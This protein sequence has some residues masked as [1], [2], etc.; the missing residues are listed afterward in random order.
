MVFLRKLLSTGNQSH[1]RFAVDMWCTWLDHRLPFNELQEE[2]IVSALKISVTACHD[3]QAW[4]FGRLEQMFRCGDILSFI[5][6][7]EKED[8]ADEY[9]DEDS[10]LAR[11]QFSSL[12]MFYQRNASLDGAA[13][14]GLVFQKLLSCLIQ[15]EKAVLWSKVSSERLPIT[16]VSGKESDI[17]KWLLDLVSN[18]KYFFHW[19][20][21]DYDDML[22]SSEQGR[23]CDKNVWWKFVARI[24]IGC[25][26]C[27]IAI[28]MLMWRQPDRNSCDTS[29]DDVITFRTDD[30]GVSVWSLMEV[31]FSFYRMLQK[32]SFQYANE[33][34]TSLSK[35]Y[36]KAASYGLH[37]VLR[38]DKLQL[39]TE[40]KNIFHETTAASFPHNGRPNG[41]S[42][43]TV[44]F[45]LDSCC[46]TIGDEYLFGKICP[47]D[48][49]L[50]DQD[51]A[52]ILEKL[53]CVYINVR[54]RIMRSPNFSGAGNTDSLSHGTD[55]MND[56]TAYILQF[57][58]YA[59]SISSRFPLSARHLVAPVKNAREVVLVDAKRG[60]EILEHICA[61][62]ER[63][64]DRM[65]KIGKNDS[66]N[67]FFRL[68]R[69]FLSDARDCVQLEGLT[70][71][72]ISC[73][74][75]NQKESRIEPTY[76]RV[77][78]HETPAVLTCNSHASEIVPPPF[79]TTH[80]AM[81]QYS[82]FEAEK[83]GSGPRSS[84]RDQQLVETAKCLHSEQRA[85]ELEQ[86]EH[87]LQVDACTTVTKGSFLPVDTSARAI[88]RHPR[89]RP[90]G[91]QV[92]LNVQHLTKA[93]TD[94]IDQMKL[95]L[96][97]GAAATRYSYAVTTGAG[98]DFPT[99][100]SDARNAFGRSSTFT[101]DIS[102]PTKRHGE[103]TEP[104]CNHDERLGASVHQRTALNRLLNLLKT[105]PE[106][107]RRL[108]DILRYGV[109]TPS[110]SEGAQQPQL[111][112]EREH[113]EL[114]D[115]HAAF[116]ATGA[117]FPTNSAVRGVPTILTDKEV[118][119]IFM[120]FDVDNIG[121]IQLEPF[122]DYCTSLG[123]KLPFSSQYPMRPLALW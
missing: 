4:S 83:P 115:F 33:M 55:G 90:L 64:L 74:S 24:Y 117:A 13:S 94:S 14:I 107:S 123:E 26:I 47:Q 39:F 101:N 23:T 95:D 57:S 112:D 3:I 27:N 63:T 59:D 6:G 1:Q 17:K 30:C 88:K 52:N 121:A 31:E 80:Q 98:L 66:S 8:V 111:E 53:L 89:G 15:F 37:R 44:V 120:Y 105:D 42:F 34:E 25:G 119:H 104:G 65:V 102:D 86:E 35:D 20:C 58:L 71:L 72:S 61:A 122:T 91:H 110:K 67:I 10:G 99:T 16:G 19:I 93:E 118:I 70:K 41:M 60:E 76:K 92:D 108:L 18:W 21:Q 75:L 46:S 49:E 81:T 45:V 84:L 22:N 43:D 29:S 68:A 56:D 87:Q 38:R 32:V 7:Y 97:Q 96:L 79:E 9:D 106:T 50:D 100:V 113:I 11:F 48:A 116:S 54:D 5:M 2:E 12:D 82:D 28:E 103:A 36:V 85:R 73:A 109:G 51:E 77:L 40:I 114:H 78:L 62:V 69:N